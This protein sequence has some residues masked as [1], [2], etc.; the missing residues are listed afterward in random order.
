MTY[1]VEVEFQDFGWRAL[2][3]AAESQGVSVEEVIQ[4]AAMYYLASADEGRISHAIAA[5]DH[6]AS[7]TSQL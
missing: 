2:N 6:S 5:S 1:R 7:A 4:H 3:D